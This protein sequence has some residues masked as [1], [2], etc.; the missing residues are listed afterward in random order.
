MKN[1]LTFDN[2]KYTIAWDWRTGTN[3]DGSE[4]EACPD[5][6]HV[7]LK[8]IRDGVVYFYPAAFSSEWVDESVLRPDAPLETMKLDNLTHVI[9]GWVTWFPEHDGN[10]NDLNGRPGLT[11]DEKVWIPQELSDKIDEQLTRE[12]DAAHERFANKK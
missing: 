12:S 9:P 7:F 6:W 1:T 5:I 11:Y 8:E 4:Y 2:E 3:P 10:Y